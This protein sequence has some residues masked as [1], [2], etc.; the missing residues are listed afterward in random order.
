VTASVEIVTQS[1]S[2][3]TEVEGGGRIAVSAFRQLSPAPSADV[4]PAEQWVFHTQQILGN[5]GIPPTGNPRQIVV[6][7]VEERDA[8]GREFVEL[9]LGYRKSLEAVLGDLNANFDESTKEP[10]APVDPAATDADET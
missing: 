7:S 9:V 10:E 2:Y 1:V 6:N 4:K 8:K 3:E 5:N